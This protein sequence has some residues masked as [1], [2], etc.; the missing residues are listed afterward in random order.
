MS[1]H[2]ELSN[3]A[4]RL[5]CAFVASLIIGLDRELH[6]RAAGMRTTILVCL[7]ACI[8]M[9]SA[10]LL[11]PQ[12]GKESGSFVQMDV[13]RLPLGIL[14]GMGFIGAGAIMRRDDGFV[15]GVTTAATLWFVTVMGLCFGAGQFL[16]GGAAFLAG[17]VTLWLLKYAE[18]HIGKDREARLVVI[19][20]REGPTEA[21]V[22]HTL[23]HPPF[24]IR[25]AFV[26]IASDTGRRELRYDLRYAAG[27]GAPPPDFVTSLA[28]RSGVEQV[29]WEV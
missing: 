12:A 21:E 13:M 10:N 18:H 16:L 8:A 1:L 29:E 27:A 24:R 3:L 26:R 4:L 15:L 9:M 20:S 7:A 23:S 28:A 11:L 14:T 5:L 25:R 6:E 19:L 2:P 17:I 22:R